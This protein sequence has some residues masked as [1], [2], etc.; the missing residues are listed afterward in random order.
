MLFRSTSPFFLDIVEDWGQGG[1]LWKSHCQLLG[2]EDPISKSHGSLSFL[3]ACKRQADVILYKEFHQQ[4]EL[5]SV[6]R[7]FHIDRY[8]QSLFLPLESFVDIVCE[9]C[10]VFP[11]G[12]SCTVSSLVWELRSRSWSSF[13][14][15]IRS[16]SFPVVFCIERIRYPLSLLWSFPG[17]GTGLK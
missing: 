5:H 13:L 15:M 16:I 12:F 9:C 11:S 3:G 1:A 14:A 17:L 7:I 10:C 8:G 4:F 6:V 2:Y